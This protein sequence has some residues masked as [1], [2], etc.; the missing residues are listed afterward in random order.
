M[1]KGRAENDDYNI[2]SR[3]EPFFDDWLID[4]MSGVTLQLHQPVRQEVV[5][6][7]NRPWE[8]DGSSFVSVFQDGD[9]YRMYYRGARSDGRGLALHDVTCYA[10]SHDG[11]NW[12]RPDLGLFEFQGSKNNNIVLGGP[13]DL[14]AGRPIDDFLAFKDDNPEAPESQRY[15]AVCDVNWKVWGGGIW[16]FV[17]PD[18]I[19]WKRI[20]DRP[21]FTDNNE[22]DGPQGPAC[23]DPYRG[24]YHAYLRGWAMGDG[25]EVPKLQHVKEK[26]FIRLSLEV[27]SIGV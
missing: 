24:I 27:T 23:W 4:E 18:G 10:E 9:I 11:I 3:L 6:E 17:S 13:H 21:L 26:D 5:L 14:D 19:H 12:E 7:F 25:E 22:Y 15:M 8:G 20:Q 16:G 2:G 1:G